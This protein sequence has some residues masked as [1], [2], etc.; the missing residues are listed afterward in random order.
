MMAKWWI[1]AGPPLHGFIAWEIF[2]EEKRKVMWNRHKV[3]AARKNTR[4]LD[5]RG[6]VESEKVVFVDLMSNPN[7]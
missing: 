3:K 4:L 5:V 2:M 7:A 1:R 6:C